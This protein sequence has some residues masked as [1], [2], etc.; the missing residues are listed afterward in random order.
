VLLPEDEFD[1]EV[2]EDIALVWA[3]LVDAADVVEAVE[4]VVEEEV[5]DPRDASDITET[6]PA[7]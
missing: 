1:E 5:P 4:V 6:I 2:T 7:P 3:E